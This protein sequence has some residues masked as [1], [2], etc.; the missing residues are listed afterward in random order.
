MNKTQTLVLIILS[1]FIFNSCGQKNIE[2]KN[3][4]Q[5]IEM[6]NKLAGTW[7]LIFGVILS[8]IAFNASKTF[9]PCFRNVWI[10]ECVLFNPGYYPLNS[11]A[12]SISFCSNRVSS[13]PGITK[14]GRTSPALFPMSVAPA[15]IKLTA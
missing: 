13:S 10:R 12:P 6:K 1:T 15:L 14:G 3:S 9:I 4:D 5:H 7:K 8:N 2:V 11:F